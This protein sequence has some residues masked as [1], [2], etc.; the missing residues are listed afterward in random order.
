M[1]MRNVALALIDRTISL[2]EKIAAYVRCPSSVCRQLRIY[3]VPQT[4]WRSFYKVQS[5]FI[6]FGY[7]T[8]TPQT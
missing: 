2:F 8:V 7:E 6:A 3:P 5:N 4:A 1:M